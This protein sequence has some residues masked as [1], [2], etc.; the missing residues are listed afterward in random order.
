[1]RSLLLAAL[2]AAAPFALSPSAQDVSGPGF[3]LAPAPYPGAPAFGATTTL[4]NGDIVVFDGQEVFQYASNGTLLLHLGGLP[5]PVFPSFV[6]VDPDE[7]ELYVGESS[8]GAIFHFLVGTSTNP[9][10]IAT[11]P[12]NYD[13]AMFDGNAL[14]VSAATC[15][16]GCGN[17]IWR[18]DLASLQARKV[19]QVPGAS[20]PIVFDPQGN[21]YYG[22]APAAFPPP[23]NPTRLYRW[24]AAQLAG[25]NVLG[26]ADAQFLAGG[27]EGASRL[28]YDPRVVAL[29][30]VEN[31]FATGATRIRRILGGPA[32]SPVVVE[33]QLFRSITNLSLQAGSTAAQFRAFQPPSD[34]A[35]SYTTSD[36][37][38]PPVRVVVQP[39]RPS[40][41]FS[42]PGTSGPGAFQLELEN[43]PHKGFARVFF[44]PSAS[45]HAPEV[46]RTVAGVPLFLSARPLLGSAGLAGQTWQW[47][48]LDAHGGLLQSYTN[49][50]G[51]LGALA[52]QF[53]L[54]DADLRVAGTSSA[55]FL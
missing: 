23:P 32:Q 50:G 55:A 33:G 53:V 29:Y 26:L 52:A 8:T 25:P 39:A 40:A 11:L 41:F 2:L 54:F 10:L 12:F 1:M 16:F 48:A 27:F 47:L 49:P 21:L 35:L 4:A 46:V 44:F 37:V 13:A 28:A 36:F 30:L 19:A 24:S 20:G 15:G 18:V 34:A 51:L 17:Q 38:A 9:D 6:L 45:A 42:G 7:D 3:A 14:F 43:G 31:S 5:N 22:T